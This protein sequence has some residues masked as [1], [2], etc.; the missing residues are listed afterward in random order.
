MNY[1]ENRK[2]QAKRLKLVL[3]RIVKKLAQLI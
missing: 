1:E 2:A 3:E